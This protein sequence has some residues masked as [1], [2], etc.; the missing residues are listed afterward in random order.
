MKPEDL[1]VLARRAWT[2]EGRVDDRL[3]EVHARIEVA[4]RRR[5]VGAVT[6]AVVAVVLALTAGLGVVALTDTEPVPPAKPAPIPTPEPKPVDEPVARRLTYA[7]GRTIHWGDRTIDAGAKVGNVAATDDG[8]LFTRDGPG[9]ESGN[10]N[11][12]PGCFG[13]IWFTDGSGINRIGRAYGTGVRGHRIE[14]SSAGSTVVWFEPT[15]SKRLPAP[16][17]YRERGEYVAYDT[18]LGEEVGRF[19]SAESAL[20]AVL[21]DAVY[22]L[23]DRSWCR[24]R[25]VETAECGRYREVMRFDTSTHLQERVTTSSYELDGRSRPRTFVTRDNSGSGPHGLVQVST[26]EL[27]REGSRLVPGDH[28]GGTTTAQVTSTGEPVR[29]R[30]P[31]GYAANSR[32]TMFMWLDDDRV[33]LV[34][35][36]DVHERDGI[37]VC[38]LPDGRCRAAATGKVVVGFS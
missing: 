7:L 13:V 30:L 38:P 35:G 18:G 36:G 29:L 33:A 21:D 14:F 6:A 26:I 31:I 17:I 8:V 1:T 37:L 32:F 3:E 20:L 5:Q 24:E 25:V 12:E 4:H 23:P 27:L 10:C 15:P 19:G 22:W 16:E 9:E 34:G 28:N 2:V 11:V